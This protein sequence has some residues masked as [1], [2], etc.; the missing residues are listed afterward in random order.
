[1]MHPN[2]H[3]SPSNP[4]LIG[5][6]YRWSDFVSFVYVHPKMARVTDDQKNHLL[7]YME[8]NIKFCQREFYSLNGKETLQEDWHKLRATLNSLPG[9]NKSVAE[10]QKV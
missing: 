3:S 2:L 4:Q 5:V 1:M 10:W 7:G 9:A 6:L 8:K